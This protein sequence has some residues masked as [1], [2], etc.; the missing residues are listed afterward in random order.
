MK[1]L[2]SMLLSVFIVLAVLISVPVPVSAESVYI[3]KIVS[4]VYDDSSSMFGEKWAYANYA[5]QA[6]CGMLNSEDQLYVTY[7][8]S[9]KTEGPEK[10]DLSA[11]GIQSAVNSI[12][13]HT[14]S[15]STPY[16]AVEVAYEKLKS[17][18]DSN[19]NTQYWLVVIT[20]GAF[21]E[22]TAM[23]D[24][25]KKDFLNNNFKDYT[26]DVMPN[27]THP[28]VTFLGIGNIVPPD[29][30]PAKGI[31]TYSASDADG[32]IDAMSEMADRISGRTRLGAAD[33]KK[34]DNKTVQVSS[35]IPLLNIVAFVQ[36][37]GAKVTA[38]TYDG[39]V[40]IPISRTVSLGYPN[41]V[42]LSGG[43]YLLGDSQQA[44][45]A[46]DYL[47]SFDQSVDLNDVVILFEPALEVR[48]SLSINGKEVSDHTKLED[49]MEG[50]KVSVS[51]KIYEM[52]TETEVDPSLLSP[53]TKFEISVSED[54][55]VVQ[56]STGKEMQLS[57]YVL[58]NLETEITATVIIEGFNPIRYSTRFTPTKYVPRIVYSIVPSFG[59]DVRNVKLDDITQNR[60]LSICF[61]VYADGV[62]ITDPNAVKALNP[63]IQVSPQGNDGS[64]IYTTDGKI[65]FTPNRASSAPSNVGSFDVE[66]TCTIDNGTTASE[67]YTVLIAKY[68]VVSVPAGQSVT[69]TEWFD[70]SVST[71]FYILKDGVKL[72]KAEVEKHISI[73]LNEEYSHLLTDVTVSADGTITVT[74]YSEEQ[75]TLTFGNWWKN[76]SYYFALEDKD[77]TV[78]LNHA[79]GSADSVIDVVGEDTRYL[80]LNVYLPLLIEILILAAILAYI[81]RY[82]TKARFAKNGVLY[83]G[84]IVRQ[85]KN[86]AHGLELR[87]V[88]LSQYNKFKNL[89][90]P[91]KE[92]TV[93]VSGV[94][95]TAV[96]GNRIQCDEN[97]PWYSDSIRSKTS[98]VVIQSPKDV[99]DYCQEHD[100]LSIHE[101]KAVCVMDENNKIISQD[102]S[103]YYFV[104]ADVNYVKV[105]ARQ[106][107]VI[108]E[109]VAFCY[110]T[111]QN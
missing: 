79:L 71:S 66:V 107:E 73:L 106:T 20:D 65:V 87:E 93:S 74:P 38:A 21:D 70:N 109:A 44:I 102:D 68:E 92:L 60:D 101:I 47:I 29:A 103:V 18:S 6:F 62:A 14:K 25:K 83:I 80:L 88:R 105:G 27:G 108:E 26:E 111:I 82:F 99:V 43:A 64:I 10:I 104:K 31:Y 49:V 7:M 72:D 42:D 63:V 61:T 69:R 51:C 96:K 8:S 55:K 37:S 56:Q 100:E 54:G 50:D 40:N 52:G 22:C 86:A 23:S 5:M 85:A 17:V 76:W 97:F 77:L 46:G 95:I 67:T 24:K 58:K 57:E 53:Q 41:Y 15:S 35:S 2:F 89:W 34:V 90:N 75:H 39:G 36:G 19:P 11:G 91:F 9:A 98:T 45:G 78:T 110:S 13:S 3:R 84:S 33:V 81:I 16:K 4:V 12:R 28:Q 94:R 59:G 48:M 1:R 32:I 30:N